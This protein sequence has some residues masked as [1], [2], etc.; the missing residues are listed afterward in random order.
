[1]TETVLSSLQ[2]NRAVILNVYTILRVALGPYPQYGWDFL[3]EIPEKFRKRSQSVCWNS[4]QQ[5]GWDPPN[6][7]IQG[8]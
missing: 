2:M 7:I 6:P 4:P 1:M 8:I 5:Y 3:E